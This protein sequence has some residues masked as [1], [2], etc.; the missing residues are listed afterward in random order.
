MESRVSPVFA[1][2]NYVDW[3]NM[4]GWNV[5]RI[6]IRDTRDA[7]FMGDALCA[8]R[9]VSGGAELLSCCKVIPFDYLVVHVEESTILPDTCS[10]GVRK[11]AARDADQLTVGTPIF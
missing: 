6:S 4:R 3:P 2:L 10:C 11:Y 5:G 9:E 1:V 8:E 7:H